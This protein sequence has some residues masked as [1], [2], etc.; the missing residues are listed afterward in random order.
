MNRKK[1]YL[2]Q[3]FVSLLASVFVFGGCR[4]DD[5]ELDSGDG[6][7]RKITAKVENGNRYDFDE[8][9]AVTYYGFSDN[10]AVLA[11]TDYAGGGFT[12]QLPE[13][14]DDRYLSPMEDYADILEKSLSELVGFSLKFNAELSEEDVNGTVAAIEAHRSGDKE[15]DFFYMTLTENESV[16]RYTMTIAEGIFMYSDKSCKITGSSSEDRLIDGIE[17]WI[18]TAAN[19]SLRK[20][21]NILYLTET[22]EASRVTQIITVTMTISSDEPAGMKWYFEDDIPEPELLSSA[23]TFSPEIRKAVSNCT[24]FLRKTKTEDKL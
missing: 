14:V 17:A 24:G 7:G 2:R 1:I 11:E 23:A 13:T 5:D 19:A 22:V 18:N 21:W 12:L 16:T 3:A 9:K 10:S 6:V 15:G 4:K 8:V 20:G